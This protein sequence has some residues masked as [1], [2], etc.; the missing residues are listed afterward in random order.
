MKI[1]QQFINAILTIVN[2]GIKNAS[3]DKTVKGK[4]LT[5]NQDGTYNV[6][7]DNQIY[8]NLKYALGTLAVSNAVWVRYPCGNKNDMYICSLR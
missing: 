1:N 7:I 4:I 3:F 8:Q 6:L 2:H 5:V